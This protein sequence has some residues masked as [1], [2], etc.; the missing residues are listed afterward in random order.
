[1]IQIKFFGSEFRRFLSVFFRSTA[2]FMSV[3]FLFICCTSFTTIFANKNN[4]NMDIPQPFMQALLQ[5]L[6][7]QIQMPAGGL[8]ADSAAFK[9]IVSEIAAKLISSSLSAPSPPQTPVHIP[10]T[11]CTTPVCAAS[12]LAEAG[13]PPSRSS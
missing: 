11:G 10:I 12:V 7:K 8:S 2:T 5:A 13:T 4:P 1:M 9:A 6:W 3:F